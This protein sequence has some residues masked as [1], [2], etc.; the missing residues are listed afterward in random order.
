MDLVT[1]FIICILAIF[2]SPLW[3]IPLVLFC[4]AIYVILI[5]F[6][7]ILEYGISIFRRKK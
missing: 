4:E 3:F 5:G 7:E 2:S 6:S 1:I